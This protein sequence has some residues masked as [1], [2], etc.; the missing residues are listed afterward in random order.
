M[1]S[2]LFRKLRFLNL[3][4]HVRNEKSK[5]KEETARQLTKNLSLNLEIIRKSLNWSSDLKIRKFKICIEEEK[6][7][8]VVF[9]DGL[10]DKR[11]INE[12]ILRPLMLDLPGTKH[13]FDRKENP[14][15][16]LPNLLTTIE[17]KKSTSKVSE[18][19]DGVLSGSTAL[20]VEGSKQAAI[21]ETRGW[22]YR[23][24]EK[25][26]TEGT[27]RGPREGFIENLQ[28]NIALL[29]RIIRDPAFTIERMQLGRRTKTDVAL[30]YIKGVA[31]EGLM[32]EV[33]KRLKRI[34]TDAIL[35]SG[36]IEQFIEDNPFS[37]FA[38][39]GNSE[40]PDKVAGK[41]LEG[42][43]A[44]LVDGTPFVLTA[45]MLLIECFQNTED[46]YT[47]P[48]FATF[49]RLIRYFSFALS[50]L[51]P[52]VFVALTTFHQELIPTPLLITIAAAREGTPFPGVIEALG[53]MIVFEILREAGVRM[54]RPM[55]QA[56]SIVGALVIGEACVAAGLI[57][58][59]M[60]IVVAFTAIVSF[61]V[62]SLADAGSALRIIF[63]VLAG[64][65][66]LFGILIGLLQLL[67][68]L[69]SLRSFGAPYLS[70]VIPISISGLKDLIVAPT[71]LMIK[72]PRDIRAETQRQKPGLMPKPPVTKIARNPMG[73][74]GRKRSE[75]G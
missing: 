48:Y 72:R 67:V 27:V 6:E 37:L 26:D 58:A 51:L 9:I 29:R 13:R 21:F 23:T 19:I 38:T 62:P 28:T 69:V 18:I 35:E 41:I 30:A 15:E 60:V 68:H 46:Y 49:M 20:L 8:A 7:A 42:R 16:L 64:T 75:N 4:L 52:A 36:Y 57:G 3:L 66:G 65:L 73:R 40:K 56:V 22:E 44:I 11:Q 70:P 17:F 25:P 32:A 47:R 54:P 63:I 31:S 24:I 2:M 55:G 5:E 14:I 12:H 61:I 34:D 59:P 39:I 71:W 50:F 45:P 33:K 10:V 1:F 74:K 53:I 43:V